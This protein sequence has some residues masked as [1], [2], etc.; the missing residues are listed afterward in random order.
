[1]SKE[2]LK[3]IEEAKR[4]GAITLDLSCLN[5][6]T[7]PTEIEQLTGL[8]TLDLCGT[9]IKDLQPLSGLTALQTLDLCHNLIKDVDPLSGLRKKGVIVYL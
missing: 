7:I 8:T 1:M 3:R 5:L 9:Q 6:K 2:A 4:T